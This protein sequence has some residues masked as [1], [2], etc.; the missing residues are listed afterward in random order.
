VKLAVPKE[1][2]PGERRVAVTPENV[3]RLI[4]M[5]F[6][7]LVEHDAGARVVVWRR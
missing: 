3:S 7:V 2:R 5:G 4:K 6:A 1:C